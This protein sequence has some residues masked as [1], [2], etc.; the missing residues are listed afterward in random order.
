MARSGRV[1]HDPH[2]RELARE[3]PRTAGVIEVNVG[4]QQPLEVLDP[5]R[6][7]TGHHGIA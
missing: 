2:V 4:E 1:N 5:V 7:Q 3:S 6:R